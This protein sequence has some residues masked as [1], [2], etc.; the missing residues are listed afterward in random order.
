MNLTTWLIL[1]ITFS[2]WGWFRNSLKKKW[3]EKQPARFSDIKTDQFTN[4][5]DGNG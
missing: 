5:Y 4:P 3:L 2:L 1:V